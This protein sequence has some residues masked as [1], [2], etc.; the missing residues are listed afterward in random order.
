METIHLLRI[1]NGTHQDLM[2]LRYEIK[3]KS[4][5][6]TVRFLI[7]FYKENSGVNKK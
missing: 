4:A 3:K 7:D 6:D 1:K 2:T 5:S